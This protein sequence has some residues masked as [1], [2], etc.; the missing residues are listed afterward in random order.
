MFY[1]ILLGLAG[2]A[3]DDIAGKGDAGH[4]LAGVFDEL[5]I[6]LHRVVAVHLLQKPVGAA[7]HRQMQVL[8]QLRLGGDGINELMAGILGVAGHKADVIIAGHGAQQVE[9]VGEIDLLFQTL[10]VAVHVLTQQGDL[11]I[12]RFHKAAE[13]RKDIA[14]LAAASRGRGRRARCSRCRSCRSRT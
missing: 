5:Q 11:L 14:G 8:A 12:A 6:L 10:A 13:L 1:K 7:L 4:G 2:E 3:H 9:Q